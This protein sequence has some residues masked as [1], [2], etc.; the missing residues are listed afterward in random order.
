MPDAGSD[1]GESPRQ[2]LPSILARHLAHQGDEHAFSLLYLAAGAFCLFAAY[3]HGDSFCTDSPASA[4]NPFW[5]GAIVG[6]GGPP[7]LSA[8]ASTPRQQRIVVQPSDLGELKNLSVSQKHSSAGSR[9]RRLLAASVR[10]TVWHDSRALAAGHGSPVGEA[11]LL[12][13]AERP[14]PTADGAGVGR[15]GAFVSALSGA[16]VI[17]ALL[18]KEG[19]NQSVAAEGRSEGPASAAAARRVPVV[20]MSPGRAQARGMA[21]LA[22]SL[23]ESNDNA[24]SAPSE[25]PAASG[26]AWA[27]RHGLV[28]MWLRVEGFTAL[29]L[30]GVS[31]LMLSLGLQDSQC[32]SVTLYI[33][34]LFQ[35][36][37]LCV[38][39]VWSFG[40]FVPQVCTQGGV[41][42]PFAYN[43]MWW[44]CAVWLGAIVSISTVICCILCC[45]VGAF[46]G[47]TNKEKNRYADDEA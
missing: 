14:S 33:V 46:V 38:G 5:G 39:C 36:F 29:F 23:G 17:E 31:I 11:K 7:S 21:P 20:G 45:F 30:P 34:A 16:G 43:A 35:A 25:G 42:D 26:G 12:F 9:R 13:L 15:G 2:K 1:S 4:G 22:Q 37:C 47:Q 28:V 19:K 44:V 24:E 32:L 10:E 27:G 41:G 18:F 40:G 8:T 3:G 6:A